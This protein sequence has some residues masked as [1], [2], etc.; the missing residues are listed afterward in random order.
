MQSQ[1]LIQLTVLTGFTQYKKKLRLSLCLIMAARNVM[2]TDSQLGQCD[3]H[4]PGYHAPPPCTATMHRHQKKK[5]K[6]KTIDLAKPAVEMLLTNLRILTTSIPLRR[7]FWS[8]AVS[9]CASAPRALLRV[10]RGPT[11][12]R[13][14]RCRQ[15]WRRVHSS[16]R[17]QDA[18]WRLRL[19]GGWTSTQLRRSRTGYTTIW[20]CISR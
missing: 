9:D 3:G 2:G 14:P 5:K 13:G 8:Y 16:S 11:R 17:G 1:T 10:L 15:R 18:C 19:L 20:R 6:K 7:W 12:R 4:V